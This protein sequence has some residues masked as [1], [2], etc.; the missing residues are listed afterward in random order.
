MGGEAMHQAYK[1]ICIM[2]WCAKLIYHDV[3]VK[4]CMIDTWPPAL[5]GQKGKADVGIGYT[6][7]VCL[8]C[9]LAYIISVHPLL[10]FND[11]EHGDYQITNCT[12]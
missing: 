3:E 11:A 7:S 12:Q 6:L 5:L 8:S 4:T 10:S 1:I 2:C 9:Y